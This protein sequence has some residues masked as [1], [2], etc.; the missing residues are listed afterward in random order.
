[1][2]SINQS[3]QAINQSIKMQAINQSI[4]DGESVT[5]GKITSDMMGGDLISPVYTIKTE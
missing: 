2:Q 5:S 3:M 4:N 1:M